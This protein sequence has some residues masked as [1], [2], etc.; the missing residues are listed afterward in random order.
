MDE[1]QL[2]TTSTCTGAPLAG[3]YSSSIKVHPGFEVGVCFNASFG[4]PR[5]ALLTGITHSMLML[6]GL[7]EKVRE[8]ALE[9]WTVM[10]SIFNVELGVVLLRENERAGK[11]KDL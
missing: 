8:M 11:G 1:L 4:V 5:K 7:M 10:S 3:R 2:S 9:V 6:L